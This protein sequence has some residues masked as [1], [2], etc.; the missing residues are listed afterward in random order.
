MLNNLHTLADCF[1]SLFCTELSRKAPDVM[2]QDQQTNLRSANNLYTVSF[3][4]QILFSEK[5]AEILFDIGFVAES[6]PGV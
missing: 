3:Y 6:S 5:T 1:I 2:A 4:S